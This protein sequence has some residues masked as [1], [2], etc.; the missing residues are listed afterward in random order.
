[1]VVLPV[2]GWGG[3]GV[4]RVGFIMSHNNETYYDNK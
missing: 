1:M 4:R 3:G 2:G